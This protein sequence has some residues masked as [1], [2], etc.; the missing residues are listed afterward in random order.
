MKDQFS[1]P[2]TI[3][4]LSGEKKFR[5]VKWAPDGSTLVWCEQRGPQGVVVAS[6]KGQA[7]RDVSADLN[8][9]GSV[10]YG[11]G[12][13]D[14]S[15]DW[16]VFV[17]DSRLWK[18]GLHT[19]APS[20]I[21]PAHPGGIAAPEISPDQKWVIYT[22]SD[23]VEDAIAIAPMHGK[24]WP[25][26]LVIDRADFYMQPTWSPDGRS[27]AWAQWRQP[28]MPWDETE[29]CL[30]KLKI[31]SESVEVES[32]EI[33]ASGHDLCSQCPRFSPDGQWLAY[34][35]DPEGFAHIWVRNLQ[36]GET[37][38]LTSGE[39]EY[40]GP[41]WVQGLR[42]LDWSPDSKELLVC[43]NER[44][45][46]QLK[47]VDLN[48]TIHAEPLAQH[49]TSV[50]QPTWS[51]LGYKAFIGSSST[52]STRVVVL[53]EREVVAARATAESLTPEVLSE[54]QSISW[55]V[56]GVD[57]FG[58]YYP[59]TKSTG[60]LPPAIIMVHGGPTSQRTA[61]FDARN[62]FFATRG[63][64]VLDVNYRGST[65]YGRAYQDALRGE[66]GIVD[67]KDLVEGAKHLALAGL[68]DPE[69]L[70]I[71]GGSSGGYAVLQ[72]LTDYPGIF[73]AGVCL[74][75]IGNLFSLAMGTH[76]FEAAYNDILVGPLP[77]AAKTYRE[78]S[79]LFKADK[80]QDALAIYHGKED[81]VVPIDQAEGIVAA[82]R[83]R[84]VPH[85]YHVY[86]NEGHGWRHPENIK[87]FY[88]TLLQF[89]QERVIFA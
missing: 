18:V 54:M 77:E 22:F 74:Y 23:G 13:F 56:D 66:W 89:L 28:A 43:A 85:T 47:R 40:G 88:T 10:G 63:F 49:Y 26:K 82:I 71:L 16:V 52:V 35:S 86:E 6:P 59:P 7:P 4:M 62:Q 57:V 3:E 61:S 32:V 60:E 69:K 20:P 5:D 72:A 46:V 17:A 65:G 48:G 38:A 42:F 34:I 51:K 84:G 67:V 44:G 14:V 64:A 9:R 11:G 55:K 12:E 15:Q 39:L 83:R 21:T 41:A 27:I 19:G 73:K 30:A 2:V 29:L 36:T 75:G 70:V 45:V 1:S 31:G 68:A 37:K 78:R 58:N 53:D 87:H 33:V 50:G 24:N 76:K 80:I 79:P 81:K 8:V 25:Q